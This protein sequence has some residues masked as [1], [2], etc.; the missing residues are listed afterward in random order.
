MLPD[1]DF[2]TLPSVSPDRVAE[3]PKWPI[4][5]TRDKTQPTPSSTGW[6]AP[7]TSPHIPAVH[8]NTTVA[9]PNYGSS[10]ADQSSGWD[11]DGGDGW[12]SAEA[13]GKWGKSEVEEQE[14]GGRW[15]VEQSQSNGYH[16]AAHEQGSRDDYTAAQSQ[17]V[18]THPS[19]N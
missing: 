6:D 14:H 7:T 11:A 18:L 4:R 17:G 19:W 3:A 8:R 1:A 5:E 13:G 15:G 2:P 9:D 16:K 10:Y 12:G